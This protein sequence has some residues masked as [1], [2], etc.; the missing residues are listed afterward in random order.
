MSAAVKALPREENLSLGRRVPLWIFR[1]VALLAGIAVFFPP[2]NPGRISEKINASAS[3]FT[4]G[5]S[6][7]TITNSMGRILRS[8]WI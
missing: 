3:L 6:Y 7:G 1:I 4:N 8:Q 5:V 2:A